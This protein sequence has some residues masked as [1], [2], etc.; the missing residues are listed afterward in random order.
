L[1]DRSGTNRQFRSGVSI[2]QSS[3]GLTSSLDLFIRKGIAKL[4]RGLRE[5]KGRPVGYR[6]AEPANTFTIADAETNR[7]PPGDE[8]VGGAEF[9]GDRA[10]ARTS[11]GQLR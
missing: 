8:H 4:D 3:E 2:D 9:Q 11:V 5:P 6:A 7:V 10:G 1:P